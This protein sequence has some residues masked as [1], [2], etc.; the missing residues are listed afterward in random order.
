MEFDQFTQELQRNL[1]HHQWVRQ[2]KLQVKK[3]M[4][5]PPTILSIPAINVSA[6]IIF[7]DHLSSEEAQK[8]LEQGAISL[9]NFIPPSK[10]GQNI[11]FGHSSDYPWRHNEYANLFTLLPQLK[12]G[13]LIMIGNEQYLYKYVVEKTVISSTDLDGVIEENPADNALILTTCYPIGFFSKRFNVIA[14]PL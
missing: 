13:D 7:H 1:S 4:T 5:A 3:P 9:N 6:P 2:R 12:P 8:K 10:A 11:I 14:K